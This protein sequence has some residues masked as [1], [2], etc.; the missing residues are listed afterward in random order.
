MV[1][2]YL[3]SNLRWRKVP[4]LKT[5]KSKLFDFDEFRL[6]V[7]YESTEAGLVKNGSELEMNRQRLPF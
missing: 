2:I 4:R 3:W 1:G 7:H 5:V 6:W